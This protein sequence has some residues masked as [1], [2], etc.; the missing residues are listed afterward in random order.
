MSIDGSAPV[1]LKHAFIKQKGAGSLQLYA[2]TGS[3]SCQELIDNLFDHPKDEK[4]ILLDLKVGPEGTSISDV[5]TGARSG[6]LAPGSKVSLTGDGS[7]GGR[8]S[9]T[10]DYVLTEND[11][12]MLRVKGSFVAEGCGAR[13]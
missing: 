11:K 8:N 6:S 10:L 9:I 3:A 5:Y 7:A 2:T 4:H 13:P 12:E 1:E